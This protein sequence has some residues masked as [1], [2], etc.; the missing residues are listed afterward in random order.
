MSLKVKN[1]NEFDRVNIMED[2]R[3]TNNLKC[4]I[5][6]NITKLGDA[7]QRDRLA[8]MDVTLLNENMLL[9]DIKK[10][11]GKYYEQFKEVNGDFKDMIL[12]G[13]GCRTLLERYRPLFP[14]QIKSS[15]NHS[16]NTTTNVTNSR[17]KQ[18]NNALNKL[19]I[20]RR[21]ANPQKEGQKHIKTKKMET[22]MGKVANKVKRIALVDLTQR[23][24][25]KMVDEVKQNLIRYDIVIEQLQNDARTMALNIMKDIETGTNFNEDSANYIKSYFSEKDEKEKCINKHK[26][27]LDKLNSIIDSMER[28][29]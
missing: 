24:T 4:D 11:I 13:T 12:S 26:S 27:H 25:K 5:M 17:L 10:N 16:I 8:E 2:Q 6:E 18:V 23:K 20:M 14:D 7:E 1:M 22:I 19:E 9:C 28:T 29:R 21:T 15:M 3:W